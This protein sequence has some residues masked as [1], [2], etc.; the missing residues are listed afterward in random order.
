MTNH[1][2]LK[3]LIL[4]DKVNYIT[5]PCSLFPWRVKWWCVSEN[6]SCID[7]TTL[8]LPD[9]GIYS[10]TWSMDSRWSRF[11]ACL[12][13]IFQVNLWTCA[14]LSWPD[15]TSQGISI[16]YTHDFGRQHVRQDH[17][18]RSVSWRRFTNGEKTWLRIHWNVRQNMCQHWTLLLHS[19]ENDSTYAWRF[20]ST[21]TIQEEE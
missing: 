19:G 6:S 17:W 7:N 2:Y 9:R 18:T 8:F 10:T 1:V 4:L 21:W 11:S 5:T 20:W 14:N 16:Q 12:F 13:H 3:F 15:I